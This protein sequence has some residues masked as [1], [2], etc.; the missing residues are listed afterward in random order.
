[1]SDPLR[2]AIADLVREHVTAANDVPR[3]R[4]IDAEA[5]RRGFSST[6]AFRSW[7][8]A[9]GVELR[10]DNYKDTW[11]SPDAVDAAVG[12]MPSVAPRRRTPTVDDIDNDIKLGRVLPAR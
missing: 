2:E 4:R 3:W 11:V 10:E 12:A 9:R 8:L 5:T 6:S 7:C 1:M